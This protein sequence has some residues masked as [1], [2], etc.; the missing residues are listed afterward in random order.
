MLV[1]PQ[2]TPGSERH[3]SVD[4]ENVWF[5]RIQ[6]AVPS[7]IKQIIPLHPRKPRTDPK[8]GTSKARFVYRVTR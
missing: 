4:T 5:R 7:R 3:S 2:E 6:Q 8:I 1:G